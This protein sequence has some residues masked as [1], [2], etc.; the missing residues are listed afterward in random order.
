MMKEIKNI[1][2]M[3]IENICFII[4]TI[5]RKKILFFT[6]VRLKH[7]YI[8]EIFLTCNHLFYNYYN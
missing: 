5:Y 6:C 7:N 4:F 8:F 1:F 2:K 3:Q